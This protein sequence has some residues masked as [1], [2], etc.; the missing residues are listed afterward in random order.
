MSAA[1]HM[2]AAARAKPAAG[3]S[4]LAVF[5]ARA[6]SRALLVKTLEIDLHTAVDELQAAA[7]ASGLVAQL[8]QDQ[9]QAIMGAAFAAV[10]DDLFKSPPAGPAPAPQ[11]EPRPVE[12]EAPDEYEGLSSTFAK[13]C[14]EADARA[15]RQRAPERPT[16]Y[17]VPISTLQTAEYLLQLG[18][19]AGWRKWFDAHSAQERAG[20]LQYLERRKRRRGK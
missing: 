18:D 14:R 10:R 7:V 9:V 13:A 20:I 3:R 8:G 4:P 1:A 19:P 6:E 16:P 15:R 5:T 11:L 17:R 12:A 2:T